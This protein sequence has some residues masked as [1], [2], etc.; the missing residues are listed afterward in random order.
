MEHI[1]SV[2]PVIMQSSGE[3][4]VEALSAITLTCLAEGDPPPA[5]TWTKEGH[6]IASSERINL[7]DN[8]SLVHIYI[9]Y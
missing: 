7:S 3:M 8:G 9:F 6:Y 1:F 4:V 2:P 5:I